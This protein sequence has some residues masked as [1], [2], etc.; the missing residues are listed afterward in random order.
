M[1][2]VSSI[3]RTVEKL[4]GGQR[5]Q[6]DEY[7]IRKIETQVLIPSGNTLVMGGLMSDSTKNIYSKVPLLGDMP[8]IG[9]AFSRRTSP[10]TSATS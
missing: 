1:P 3:F 4:S 10:A 9:R 6:A 8:L 2:E 5:N 7:D